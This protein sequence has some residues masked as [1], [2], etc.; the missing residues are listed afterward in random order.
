MAAIIKAIA[1]YSPRVQIG[2]AAK[3]DDLIKYI[4]GRSVLTRGM[5]RHVLSELGDAIVFFNREGRPV[6]AEGIGIFSPGIEK[7]GTLKV[8]FKADKQIKS[9]LD[10]NKFSGKI[11]NRDMVGKSVECLINRWNAEHPADKIK[12]S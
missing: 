4:A 2:T 5:V 11:R 9:E 6:K 3:E 7:D 12:K 8:N 10:I 1:L